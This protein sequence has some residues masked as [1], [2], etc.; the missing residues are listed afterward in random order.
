MTTTYRTD[1]MLAL[2]AEA[3]AAKPGWDADTERAIA[4]EEEARRDR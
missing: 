4:R 1:V 3:E 2:R